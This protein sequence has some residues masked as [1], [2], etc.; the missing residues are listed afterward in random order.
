[1]KIFSFAPM[2][3]NSRIFARIGFIIATFALTFANLWNFSPV[4]AACTIDGLVY[5]DY[6][7]DGT[8]DGAEPGVAGILV[9][10]YQTSVVPPGTPPPSI[11]S[12]TV[13]TD[14]TDPTGAYNLN[15][16]VNG[17]VRIEFTQI[18]EGLESGRFGAANSSTT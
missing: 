14:T 17:Q 16:T 1:M 11:P 5:Q 4:H 15:L 3:R 12:L 13:G 8:Q 10:A 7:A 9:T 18:P 6:D 2:R